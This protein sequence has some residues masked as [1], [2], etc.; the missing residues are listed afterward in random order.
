MKTTKL[1]SLLILSA[2]LLTLACERENLTES[3]NNQP[4][5]EFLKTM[6]LDSLVS[7]VPDIVVDDPVL[8]DQ[9]SVSQ[10]HENLLTYTYDRQGKLDF[11]SYFRNN[12]ITT[13]ASADPVQSF[14]YMRDK[15]IYNNV[16][17]LIELRKYAMTEQPQLTS[18]YLTKSY[19]YNT[20]GLLEQIITR[21][22]GNFS[23]W[24]KFEFLFYD[25]SGLMIRKV[26]KESN[27]PSRILSYAYDKSGRLIKITC[28]SSES[29]RLLFICDL[30]YD[31][32]NNIERKE[33]YYPLPNAAS[34]TDVIRKWVVYYKYDTYI[35][36]FHDFKLP[37]SS[38]FEWMDLVS[39]DNITAISF[40]NGA[41][42]TFVFYKYHYNNLGYPVLRY[43]IRSA[44]TDE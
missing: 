2:L 32:L 33:F 41:F 34:I 30:F 38:L 44:T 11:I 21:M 19:K 43:R 13:A 20:S 7:D 23:S 22:P 26:V 12:A 6:D 37:V 28:Y 9:A 40:N 15:F 18:L 10:C 14:A 27:L 24:D 39:P 35:N 17:Q 31:N 8:Q 42:D 36:P 4:D 16:G 29:S 3:E 25:K 5:E 1:K